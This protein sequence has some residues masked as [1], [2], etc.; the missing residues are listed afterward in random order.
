[1]SLIIH[2]VRYGDACNSSSSHTV[3]PASFL[4]GDR[5]PNSWSDDGQQYGWDAFMLGTPETKAGYVA[6]QLRDF[7]SPEK[8]K[9]WTGVAVAE[10]GYVDHQSVW[11]LKGLPEEDLERLAKAVI[12]GD[13]TILGGND[14]DYYPWEGAKE[15]SFPVD[16]HVRTISVGEH[17]GRRYWTLLSHHGDRYRIEAPADAIDYTGRKE[18]RIEYGSF[19]ELIDLKITD[20]CPF[21]KDCGFCYMGSTKAGEVADF[22]AVTRAL[23]LAKVAGTMEI[24]LGGGEPTLFPRFDDIIKYGHTL[25]LS[26]NVTTKNFTWLR[27]IL[28]A[29]QWPREELMP[30]AIA[31]SVNTIA[32][33]G[34]L[35]A[36]VRESGRG[37]SYGI[38]RLVIQ[39][40][41]ALL[42]DET[43]RAILPLVVE[44]GYRW[45]VLGYK[46]A[47]RG[48]GGPDDQAA[49]VRWVEILRDY[50]QGVEKEW[51]VRGWQ[52]LIAVDSVMVDHLRPLLIEAKVPE[53]FYADAVEGAFSM[54]IDAVKGRAAISSFDS[55]T[56]PF[57]EDDVE[58]VFQELQRTMGLRT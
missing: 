50:V 54:A 53:V 30:D 12:H 44:D 5:P 58:D 3:V 36:A 20:A 49:N 34:K 45:T 19:P 23:D 22:Y 16:D 48:G 11:G 2:S 8:I 6:Q 32:D 18:A 28:D 15:H 42:D 7:A 37:A 33:L 26:M 29:K 27:K 52:R 24:A 51:Q 39:S 43:I 1:M 31:V 57:E 56:V 13:V 4:T 55:R 25:G 9:E 14:N 38:P 47:G 10:D 41:P 46:T 35:Q 17:E 40:I 21:E